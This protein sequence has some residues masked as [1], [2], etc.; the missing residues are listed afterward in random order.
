MGQGCARPPKDPK[1]QAAEA[2]CE[3]PGRKRAPTMPPMRLYKKSPLKAIKRFRLPAAGKKLYDLQR[4]KEMVESNQRQLEKD[5]AK[6]KEKVAEYAAKLEQA[7]ADQT[8]NHTRLASIVAD[9]EGLTTQAAND[10]S[11]M[12][13]GGDAMME[14]EEGGMDDLTDDD[15]YLEFDSDDEAEWDNAQ[16][17][18]P[19]MFDIQSPLSYMSSG[20]SANSTSDEKPMTPED[21]DRL[22]QP[23]TSVLHPRT[24]IP[25]PEQH[26]AHC[27][28]NQVDTDL[29][30]GTSM[31]FLRDKDPEKN[32]KFQSQIWQGKSR[33]YTMQ[34]QGKFK[35]KPKGPLCFYLSAL[36]DVS[37]I[38]RISKRLAKL[39]LAFARSWEKRID[40][41]FAV[42]PGKPLA[43]LAPISPQWMGIIE[44]QPGGE[45]PLLGHRLPSYKECI[46][47]TGR[48]LGNVEDPDLGAT[49]TFEFYTANLDC[50]Y[51]KFANIPVLPEISLHRLAPSFQAVRNASGYVGCLREMGSEDEKFLR[52]GTGGT[53]C[54]AHV[55]HR[56]A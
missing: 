31:L 26:Q 33:V 47:I 7:E 22:L 43:L 17:Q 6:Y 42:S 34:V 3:E 23:G 4:E 48:D 15:L 10:L 25:L 28:E 46:D 19:G 9:L 50:V 44:T 16:L 38:G 55:I 27:W 13:D 5:T 52:E 49:Y 39:W 35:R 37:T 53:L 41:N 8:A 20:T 51:W 40:I 18:E 12:G 21:L 2:T 24:W 11:T 30:V 56:E 54:M 32:G 29:F 36:D 45:V 14:V 1:E